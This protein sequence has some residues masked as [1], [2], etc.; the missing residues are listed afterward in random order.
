MIIKN[1]A[2]QNGRMSPEL[3]FFEC[4]LDAWRENT[5]N[6]RNAGADATRR[7]AVLIMK[8]VEKR[9]ESSQYRAPRFH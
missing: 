6:V 4:K 9:T 8:R 2:R 7:Y 5:L 3:M 1:G